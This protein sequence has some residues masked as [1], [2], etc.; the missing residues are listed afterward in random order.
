MAEIDF[1]PSRV[2]DLSIEAVQGAGLLGFGSD[3][4]PAA[5]IGAV[6]EGLPYD[7]FE[8]L[9]AFLDVPARDAG[10]RLL[11]AERTLARRR[12]NGRF[13]PEESDRLLRLARLAE[14][15]LVVF[16]GEAAPA[17][18]WLTQPKRLL[19]GESPLD[20]AD[21]E[22]GAREVE[23]MLYAIEFTAAA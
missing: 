2:A 3:C 7:A 12:Q 16:E 8:R 1:A 22:A 15:A 6:R 18:R 10:T 21:T 4:P 19:N 9:R 14:M 11:I 17:R 13:T 5:L 23:D 20:R